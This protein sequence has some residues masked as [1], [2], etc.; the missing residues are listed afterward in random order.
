VA[1]APEPKPPK[2]PRGQHYVPVWHL[3]GFSLGTQRKVRQRPIWRY[4]K[5]TDVF[6]VVPIGSAAMERDFYSYKR[7]DG[8][9]DHS[10]E[11]LIAEGFDGPGHGL[12]GRLLRREPLTHDQRAHLA[13]YVAFLHGRVPV[14]RENTLQI[15]RTLTTFQQYH[16]IKAMTPTEFIAFGSER[17]LEGEDEELAAKQGEILE[18]LRSGRLFV[19]PQ[20]TAA[21]MVAAGAA[22]EG[23]GPLFMDMRWTIQQA[24][25]GFE[26]VIGD[27]PV[28][29]FSKSHF[30]NPNT[31]DGLGFAAQDIRVYTPLTK[32]HTLLLTHGTPS[33]AERICTPAAVAVVNMIEWRG[34]QRYVF[35]S[36]E[37]VLRR[38]AAT[39]DDE[40][41]RRQPG[42]GIQVTGADLD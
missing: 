27:S 33:T 39:F 8:T 28:T 2:P 36:S 25:L 14:Q 20:E 7:E 19:G 41:A 22:I 21:T 34:A 31:P 23:I 38:V 40:Q 42:S 26:F 10:I 15:M 13:A 18:D 6:D 1:A 9:L 30:E 37:A 17:G 3:G 35:G 11:P 16:Y 12:V 32:S 24:P 29:R 5:K 4:C